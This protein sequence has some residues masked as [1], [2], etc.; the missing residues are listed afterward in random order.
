MFSFFNEPS[1]N[2]EYLKAKKPEIHFDYD[3]IMHYAH[4]TAFTVAKITQIDL[5]KDIQ[6]SLIDAMKGGLEFRDWKEKIEPVLAKKGWLGN[7]ELKNPRTGKTAKFY[8]GNR[9]LKTIYKT[10]LRVA[11][12]KASYETGIKSGAKFIRYIAVLDGRTRKSHAALNGVIKPIDD[13]F[14]DKNYPPNDWNCRCGAMFLDDDDLK[15]HGW[16]PTKLILPNVASKD[17]AYNVGRKSSA[18]LE[19]ILKEKSGRDYAK[20]AKQR[21]LKTWQKGLDDAIDELLIKKNLK[22]PIKAFQIGAISEFIAQKV[23]EILG[24]SLKNSFI[25]GDKSG[26]LHIKD[27]RKSAYNQA[28]RVDE[29]RQIV[30]ILADENTPVSIDT[31]NN[32]I[33]FWF[34][35]IKNSAKINKIAVDLNYKLK[36]FGVT[37]YVVTIG[38]VNKTN[39]DEAQYTKIR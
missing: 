30:E 27:E 32:N 25:M 21:D 29:L 5:L 4:H 1:A 38:K 12:A 8:V 39:A 10:N 20:F 19:K 3:E 28:L 17:W 14:W 11:A 36:K 23:Q 2:I 18:N 37:N 16:T 31:K 26:I 22:S 24:I 7:V 13:K 9:R 34:D 15:S 33:I 35:D 6:N